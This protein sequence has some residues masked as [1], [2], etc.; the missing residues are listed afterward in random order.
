MAP[1]GLA[2]GLLVRAPLPVH[3]PAAPGRA[4]CMHYHTVR[5]YCASVYPPDP[6]AR[7]RP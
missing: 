1:S 6:R 3:G 4:G 2:T 5:L 7:G